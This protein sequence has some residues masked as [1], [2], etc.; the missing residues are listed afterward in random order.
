MV[1]KILAIN[2]DILINI[3]GYETDATVAAKT[4]HFIR[5]QF[6]SANVSI[7]ARDFLEAIDNIDNRDIQLYNCQP[8][9][10][11]NTDTR[12]QQS[13]RNFQQNEFVREN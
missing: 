3:D 4:E 2:S 5:K 6:P 1:S 10:Y 11:T 9:L 7:I 8:A 13:S 12:C